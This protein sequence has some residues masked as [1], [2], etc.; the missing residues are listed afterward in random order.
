MY[1]GKPRVHPRLPPHDQAGTGGGSIL[2]L[3]YPFLIEQ[4]LLHVCG[5]AYRQ[6]LEKS[7]TRIGQT[8]L[9]RLPLADGKSKLRQTTIAVIAQTSIVL[10]S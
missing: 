8:V 2:H 6:A 7:S 9:V 5:I 10:R 4:E 3:I 1:P